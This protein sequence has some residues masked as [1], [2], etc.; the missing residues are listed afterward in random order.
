M[1]V[2]TLPWAVTG[3]ALTPGEARESDGRCSQCRSVIQGE[4]QAQRTTLSSRA[5][6][7]LRSETRESQR[8]DQSLLAAPAAKP[9]VPEGPR[10]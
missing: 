5:D 1:S 3:V 8:E 6:S 7:R 2:Q 10:V 4:T 9:R